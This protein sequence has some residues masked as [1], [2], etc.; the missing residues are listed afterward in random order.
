M[1]DIWISW[2]TVL[3]QGRSKRI[4]GGEMTLLLTIS[5]GS[6]SNMGAPC[7]CGIEG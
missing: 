4:G 1:E 5:S 6:G 7:P 2:A 3:A